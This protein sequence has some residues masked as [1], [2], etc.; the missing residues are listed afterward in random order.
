SFNRI[1]QQEVPLD[2]NAN[3]IQLFE[4]SSQ[5]RQLLMHAAEAESPISV[6]LLLSGD[7]AAGSRWLHALFS[8][9][10]NEDDE[11]LVE[12]ILYD[13]S[14]RARRE[15]QVRLEAERD[16]LTQLYNRRAGERHLEQALSEALAEQQTCALM[17]IDLDRFKPI[18]D[19]YGHEAGDRVLVAISQRLG[20]CLRKQDVIIRWGGDEFVVLVFSGKNLEA[21]PLVADK[22]LQVICQPIDIG[23]GR[24]ESVGASIGISLF[25]LHGQQSDE[26]IAKADRA[27]YQVKEQG[28]NHFLIYHDPILSSV[29][30]SGVGS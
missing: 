11:L 17:M 30:N 16:A 24:L 28:R 2:S 27:M 22:L 23:A 14:E 4:D 13:I 12:C 8:S 3:F 5:V 26:L 19:T 6:D 18:N 9:V 25:P 29:Q 7:R 15:Q 1:M 10:R 21:V 20:Q